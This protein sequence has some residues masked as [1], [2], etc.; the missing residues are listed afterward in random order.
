RAF[1]R[2]LLGGLLLAVCF[3]GA[4]AHAPVLL[5]PNEQIT[6]DRRNVEYPAGFDLKLAIDNL[7]A[8]SAIAFDS[9][10]TMLIAEAGIDGQEPR[11]FAV[12][13]DLTTTT[14]YPTAQRIPFSPFQPGFQIY[15][16]IGGMVVDHHKI[17]VSHRDRDDRGVITQFGFDGSHRVI[18]GALPA[19]GDYGV[20]DLVVINGRLYFGVGSAT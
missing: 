1:R 15:G 12:K 7:N 4:C 20:T 18:Q 19:Q 5:K 14:V 6:V 10:G 11:I 8:P 2:C 16:P 3:V 13:P 17:Y 9:D